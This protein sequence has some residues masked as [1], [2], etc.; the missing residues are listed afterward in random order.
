MYKNR[1]RYVL[2]LFFSSL[3]VPA[4][5]SCCVVWVKPFSSVVSSRHGLCCF[6]FGI[7]PAR[8]VGLQLSSCNVNL[9]NKVT[10]QQNDKNFLSCPHDVEALKLRLQRTQSDAS[11]KRQEKKTH[12][13]QT[14]NA[15]S[16]GCSPTRDTAGRKEA[17]RPG[18]NYRT[19]K[20]NKTKQE[21]KLK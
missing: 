12:L 14:F 8:K 18:Q 15:A 17:K 13:K 6:N 5:S 19:S 10:C 16:E 2:S 4:D 20:K 21:D 1:E 3:R 7:P 9:V 11:V